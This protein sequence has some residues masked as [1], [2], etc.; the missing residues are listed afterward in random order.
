MKDLINSIYLGY[1]TEQKDHLTRV[2]M[3][4][5]ICTGA[6]TK[7]YTSRVHRYLSLHSSNLIPSGTKQE[8]IWIISAQNKKLCTLIIHSR[9]LK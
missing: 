3:G 7:K 2:S 5:H 4:M 8:I 9:K 1:S 6:P